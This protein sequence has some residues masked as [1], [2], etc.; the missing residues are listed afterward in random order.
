MKLLSLA[1][2]PASLLED[3]SCTRIVSRPA[4][5]ACFDGAMNAGRHS[6]ATAKFADSAQ[7]GAGCELFLVE[8]DSAARSVLAVRDARTQAVLPLQ[9]KPLNAWRV[10]G[11][12]VRGN[13]LYRQLAEVLGI[14]HPCGEASPSSPTPLRFERVVLLFDPDADGIH[15]EAL[16][17]LYFA[18]WLPEFVACGQLWRVRAPMFTLTHAG[19]GEVA[20]AYSPAHRDALLA[21]MRVDGVGNVQQHRHVGLGSLPPPLLRRACIDPATRAARQVGREDVEAVLAA[22]GASE[23]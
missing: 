12:R 6:Q 15:I 16:M 9:G 17:L 21:S 3:A 13:I 14:G 18:R 8:G 2:V 20:Q 7:H 23:G 10:D 19:T 5:W 1:I 22:F 11:A 4:P